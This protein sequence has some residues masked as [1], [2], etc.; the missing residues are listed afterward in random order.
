M[1][2]VHVGL[3]SLHG[4]VARYATMFD[5]LEVRP[6]D[7]AL[8]KANK[9]RQWRKDVPPAFVFSVVLPSIVSELRQD[10]AANAALKSALEASDALQARCL[11]VV[12]PVAVTPTALNK[13]R[14]RAL[15][16][17]LPS[18][19]VTIAW[20]PRG[21]WSVEESGAFAKELGVS[22]IVDAAQ[23]RPP[24]GGVVYTRLR[25][26]GASTR[27]GPAAI[28]R[29]RESLRGRREC[30]VVVETDAA[31]KIAEQL[32]EPLAPSPRVAASGFVKPQVKMSAEDDEQ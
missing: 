1:T 29:V 13:K 10:P 22:L 7:T 12:T 18:D 14:L 9:L 2:T 19:V 27:L 32:R 20:E 15:V 28:A 8:P 23:D 31:K 11:V 25:G 3:P 26:I 21:V 4:D 16:E 6:V 24:R 5:L 17:K 30:F